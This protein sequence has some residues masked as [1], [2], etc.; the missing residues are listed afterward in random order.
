MYIYIYY[1]LKKEDTT[2]R[3]SCGC[4]GCVL[5]LCCCHGCCCCCGCCVLL[6]LLIVVVVVG[7][8]YT[9]VDPRRGCGSV[10]I[11]PSRQFRKSYTRTRIYIYIVASLFFRRVKNRHTPSYV[12]STVFQDYRIILATPH[13]P[14][15]HYEYII[16]F[17]I[18][19]LL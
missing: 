19:L 15:P 7:G 3:E 8:L 5:W 17:I 9:C 1:K 4:C 14:P 2:T 10:M 12:C 6:L 18:F 13:A 11:L 16:I